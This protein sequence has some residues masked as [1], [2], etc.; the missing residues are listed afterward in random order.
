MV[1]LNRSEA[2]E[3]Q[4]NDDRRQT[5]FG[6]NGHVTSLTGVKFKLPVLPAAVV[7]SGGVMVMGTSSFVGTREKNRRGRQVGL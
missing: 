2:C 7:S 3:K 6:D 5:I 4:N 1:V